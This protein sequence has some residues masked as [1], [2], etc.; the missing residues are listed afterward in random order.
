MFGS[1]VAVW[2]DLGDDDVVVGVGGESRL[3][4]AAQQVGYDVVFSLDVPDVGGELGD[5][6]EVSQLTIGRAVELVLQGVGE[7]LVVGEDVEVGPS[8]QQVAIVQEAAVDAEELFVEGGVATFGVGEL[9]A[10]E[11]EG[12]PDVVLELFEYGADGFVAGVGDEAKWSV[13]EVRE[14]AEVGDCGAGVVEGLARLGRPFDGLRL[15]FV[16]RMQDADRSGEHRD[17]P[18]VEVYH[19]D[20]AA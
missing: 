13:V 2:A 6:V 11:A 16:D 3:A 8:G 12:L 18:A 9:L 10:V 4:V 19:P 14:P 15:A 7:R 5:V 20:E 17:E 1:E